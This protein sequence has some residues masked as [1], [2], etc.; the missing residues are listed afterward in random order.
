MGTSAPHSTEGCN[1]R[2]D[3]REWR[4]WRLTVNFPAVA[5]GG[6]GGSYPQISNNRHRDAKAGENDQTVSPLCRVHQ[7]AL[8]GRGKP[9]RLLRPPGVS[10]DRHQGLGTGQPDHQRCG[11]WTDRK[12]KRPF[13]PC[14]PAARRRPRLLARGAGGVLSARSVTR[15]SGAQQGVAWLCDSLDLRLRS[16]EGCGSG[17]S[18][19]EGLG[20][21]GW[22]K[23]GGDDFKRVF[24]AQRPRR[25]AHVAYE[26]TPR[27]VD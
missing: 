21:T 25:C 17:V 1:Q 20:T 11:F 4:V 15:S 9:Q 8:P 7:D 23:P 12:Y 5:P 19:C 27:V 16:A 22:G 13:H 10:P 6:P 24:K 2:H 3:H 14:P 18:R 26:T